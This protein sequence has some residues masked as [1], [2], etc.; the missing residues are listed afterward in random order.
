[1]KAKQLFVV[2]SVQLG[3]VEGFKLSVIKGGRT[4]QLV[5]VPWIG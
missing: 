5:F 3:R 1:M 2:C 4:S